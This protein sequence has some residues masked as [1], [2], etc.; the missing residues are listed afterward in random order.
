[1]TQNHVFFPLILTCICK[2]LFEHRLFI[3]LDRKLYTASGTA[4]L[5][6][7]VAF[8]GIPKNHHRTST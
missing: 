2:T 3:L 4:Y 1:M 6:V 7:P 8:A 5:L